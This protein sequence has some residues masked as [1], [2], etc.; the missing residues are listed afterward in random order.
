M[1]NCSKCEKE[2][3]L[4]DFHKNRSAKDGHLSQCKVCRCAKVA[5]YH[6]KTNYAANKKYLSS[7]RGCEIHNRINKSYYRSEHGKNH[8][9][10]IKTMSVE[11]FLKYKLSHVKARKKWETNIDLKYLLQL[12]EKQCGKCNI[13]MVPMTHSYYD[14]KCISID[15]ID[16][17]K[18]YIKN[19]VQLVCR[20]I[21]LGKQNFSNQD[22]KSFICE[23]VENG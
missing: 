9:R 3:P 10:K 18:G 1:K 20:A 13:S 4:N 22:M 6:K 19:N 21:N 8:N 2:K 7:D 12:Y 5:A 17:S 14:L 15:R 11:Q 16:S 23:V